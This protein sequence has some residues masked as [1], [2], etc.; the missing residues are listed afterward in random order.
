MLCS[1]CN[2]KIEKEDKVA[3][4]P[5][6]TIHYECF[7]GNQMEGEKID[8]YEEITKLKKRVQDLE[9][10]VERHDCSIDFKIG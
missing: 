3:H 6:G 4:G 10:E 5:D 2:E 9:R 7:K 1:S 8:L